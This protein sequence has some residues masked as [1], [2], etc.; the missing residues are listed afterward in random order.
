MLYR[1][2][3]PSEQIRSST[4]NLQKHSYLTY[5]SFGLVALRRDYR[6]EPFAEVHTKYADAGLPQRPMSLAISDVEP[7]SPGQG[8]HTHGTSI[9]DSSVAEISGHSS[10]TMQPSTGATSSL[11]TPNSVW[12]SAVMSSDSS[13]LPAYS[14]RSSAT[15]SSRFSAA[16]QT[17]HVFLA[18]LEHAHFGN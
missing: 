16:E 6:I 15:Y 8:S 3:A 1:E 7:T 11:V 9:Y 12:S 2:P 14:G 13:Q 18:Q 17:Q 4:P 10:M 5:L